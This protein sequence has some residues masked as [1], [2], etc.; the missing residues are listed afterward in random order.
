MEEIV[1]LHTNDLHSHL[2]NWPKIRR[3]L[4]A[5]KQHY[6]FEGKTV[7][8]VDLGDFIDRWHPLT[9][10]TEGK[11]N[12]ALMNEVAYDVVTIGNNEGIG[13]SKQ[14]LNALYQEA[15]F[16]VLVGNLQ[17]VTTKMIPSWIK[18]YKIIQTNATTRVGF[19][20]LTAPF[21]LTYEPNGWAVA[22]VSQVLPE[23]LAEVWPK[24]DILVL[25]SHLGI[26]EDQEIALN[27]PEIDLIIGSH[28]HH[29]FETGKTINDV[30]LAAAGKFGRYIG[31][32]Q[33]SV[34]NHQLK[35]TK[36]KTICTEDLPLMLQDSLEIQ[37]YILDGQQQL[38][39][40][41]I[42]NI[43]FT[44]EHASF[45]ALALNACKELAGVEAAIL[46]SGLF[47][48]NIPEGEVN[49]GQLHQALPHPMHLIKVTLSGA[50][51]IHMLQE[52]NK[53]QPYL[54]NFPITGMGFRG[55]VF[56]EL[57][58]SGISY[59]TQTKQGF[60]QNKKIELTQKYTFVTV[61]HLLFI[62]FFPSIEIDGQIEF[63]FPDMLRQVVGDYLHSY[64]PSE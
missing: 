6:E 21:P 3:Y 16:D 50:Q 34:F 24:C 13:L 60:W 51:L 56:G 29:L 15:N 5:K 27:Y 25:L 40:K 37:Q 22:S 55:K 62:P 11:A 61:D 47:L 48:T 8:T 58:Y 33:L 43:P 18:S 28:T 45:Y 12:V 19:I 14:Q 54:K 44:L 20:A 63:I 41:I 4:C 10:S 17:D 1:I 31:E 35:N 7:I 49:V 36:V 46:N 53:N 2:E 32:I 9:E 38:Q 59:D 64:Y 42:A 30:Q 57:C 23:L 52:M 39:K 26:Q